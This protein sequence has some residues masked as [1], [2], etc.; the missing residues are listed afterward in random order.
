MISC[1]AT[2]SN[3]NMGHSISSFLDKNQFKVFQL[4]NNN[5]AVSSIFSG[6]GGWIFGVS[7]SFILFFEHL[8]TPNKYSESRKQF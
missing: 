2:F 1:N 4:K 8:R 5:I 6:A 3:E 7:N